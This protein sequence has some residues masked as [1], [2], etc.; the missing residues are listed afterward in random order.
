MKIN[1]KPELGYA[2]ILVWTLTSTRTSNAHPCGD[3]HLGMQ[4]LKIMRAQGW[5]Y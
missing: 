3:L 1:L 5:N 4:D 2:W